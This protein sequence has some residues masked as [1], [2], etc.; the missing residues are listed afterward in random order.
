MK[1]TIIGIVI[2]NASLLAAVIFAVL[3]IIKKDGGFR[4]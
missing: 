1:L 2:L 4:E 3:K